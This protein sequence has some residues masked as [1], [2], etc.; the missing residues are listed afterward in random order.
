VS[1]PASRPR[2]SQGRL[3]ERVRD[4][5][6][7]RITRQE[8]GPGAQLPTERDLSVEYGVSRVTVRRALAL[9]TEEGLV[10]AIQGRGT[11]VASERLGEPADSLL[12]FHDMV[13][14]ENVVVSA[15]PLR[16]EVRPAT[17]R[18]GETFGIAPG[19]RLFELVRLRSLDGLPVAVDSNLLPLSFDEGLP[20]LDWSIESLYAR[21]AAA[22][23]APVRADYAIEAQAADA[24]N[25]ELLGAE[26]GSPLLVA[27]SQAFDPQ[28]RLVVVG[29]IAYRGDRYRFRSTQSAT[30]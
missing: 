19:A 27:E 26:R 1:T 30:R 7:Q 22:G 28:G 12:S 2:A 16:V 4:D 14:G 3:T 21:L 15:E 25:A 18:E 29:A 5:L 9:L 11:F 10:Y 20:E 23:H 8:L 6:A 13:A 17:L 24:R